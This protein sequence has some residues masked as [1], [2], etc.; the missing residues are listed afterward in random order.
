MLSDDSRVVPFVPAGV[1]TTNQSFLEFLFGDQWPQV[2]VTSF[3]RDP[4]DTT[5]PREDW[6]AWLAGKVLNNPKFD[7][8]NT[9]FCP[10]L[11]V[12]ETRGTA[13]LRQ[14]RT[15]DNF[16]SLHVIIIDDIPT[17]IKFVEVVNLLRIPPSYV[18]ETS[19]GNHQ[20][21]WKIEPE[22]N[23]AWVK[24]MLSQLDRTLGGADNLTNPVAWRR[25][26]VGWN[27][28]Q[29]LGLGPRGFRIRLK[30]GYP[31][32]MIRGLDWPSDIEP[33]IGVVIPLTTL[34]RG[35]GDGARPDD[36][37]LAHDPIY[38]ALEAAGHIVGNRLTSDKYWAAT[39]K[40]PW[41]AHHGPTR[42]LTGAEYVPAIAGQRGWFHCFHCERRNQAEF[43]EQ[44]DVVLRDEGAKIVAAFE[45]DEIDPAA[46]LLG[47][48]SGPRGEAIDLWDRKTP[49][50]WPGGILPAPLEDTIQE[51][52][53][54]DGLD[55]GALGA[56]MITAA[57]G[58]ADKRATLTP[59]IGSNWRVLPVLWLMLIAEPGQRK[60]AILGHLLG[61]LRKVNAERMRAHT[62][63]VSLWRALTPQQKHQ[64]PAPTVR[65]LLAED[66]TI[67]KLQEWMAENP[68]GLL[69]L[70][71][72]LA[73]LFE[74]GRYTTGTGAA[75]RVS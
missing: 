9:Y 72:E 40:C 15:I 13:S 60:T 29:S 46:I 48:A 69:Y 31:G 68:R 35:T 26:P 18:I 34:D 50:T 11:L 19:P 27:T 51:L 43:K 10:S 65:A 8:G 1:T 53:E 12:P 75:E 61:R 57:S 24:G 28:K 70:R 59:Y 66:T 58:A 74:F 17:K 49:P 33:M 32:P 67:E 62:R 45:F 6:N 14:D 25:L 55:L 41:I 3:K 73:S 16:K 36:A 2:L 54:R 64:L 63:D 22:T 4:A 39:I 47:P 71:D 23:L 38:R 42:P 5:Q 20:A 37:V 21:G 52:A 44:L 56:S 7:E 30:A